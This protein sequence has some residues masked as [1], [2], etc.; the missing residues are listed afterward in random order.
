MLRPKDE[1]LSDE[2]YAYSYHAVS[3]RFMF[4]VSTHSWPLFFATVALGS[5]PALVSAL[6]FASDLNSVI[7]H[8]R[9]FEQ[10][11]FVRFSIEIIRLLAVPSG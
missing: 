5:A 8:W 9:I 10:S 6:N 3:Q 1:H 4:L 7:K 2:H 11:V